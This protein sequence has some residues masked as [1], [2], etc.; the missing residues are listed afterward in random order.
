[1]EG[2]ALSS[3]RQFAPPPDRALLF[4]LHNADIPCLPIFSSYLHIFGSVSFST[5]PPSGL[6][7]DPCP[8]LVLAKNRAF[9][10]STGSLYGKH[11]MLPPPRSG[12]GN[13]PSRHK[14][15]SSTFPSGRERKGAYVSFPLNNRRGPPP[16]PPITEAL[17]FSPRILFPPLKVVWTASPSRISFSQGTFLCVVASLPRLPR[18]NPL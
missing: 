14:D 18:E 7:R 4:S 6:F 12:K 16:S 10:T 1:M 5:P 9:T 2:R 15:N 3:V 8:P 17:G 11:Q 13:Q